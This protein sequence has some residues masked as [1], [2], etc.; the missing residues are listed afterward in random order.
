MFSIFSKITEKLDDREK[1]KL[2]LF[3]AGE[4]FKDLGINENNYTSAKIL[5]SLFAL[6]MMKKA[7]TS[8]MK[9]IIFAVMAWVL[10]EWYVYRKKKKRHK[11]IETELDSLIASTILF[12]EQGFNQS[13]LFT[14]LSHRI[15][16]D[17]PLHI[18]IVRA[19]IKI[20]K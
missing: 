8:W 4:Q 14:M 10:I 5:F 13:E 18:E 7:E 2:K 6:L 17:N 1:I 16:S 3:Q 9:P 11:E 19:K 15:K 20:N 12:L